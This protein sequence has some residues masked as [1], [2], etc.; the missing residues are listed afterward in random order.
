MQVN[1]TINTFNQDLISL[2]N[3]NN[4][5]PIGVIYY[6]LKDCFNEVSKAYEQILEKERQSVEENSSTPHKLQP[7]EVEE[8]NEENN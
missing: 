6:I 2:I 5:L 3:K 4:N 1:N 7:D 8:I